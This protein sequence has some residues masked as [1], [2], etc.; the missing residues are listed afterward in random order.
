MRYLL[1]VLGL[2]VLC[3]ACSDI[4]S[5]PEPELPVE[6]FGFDEARYDETENSISLHIIG[7]FNT[8]IGLSATYNTQKR[9]EMSDYLAENRLI[10]Q[11]TTIGEFNREITIKLTDWA[12]IPEKLVFLTDEPC[13]FYES[14]SYE[15]HSYHN[16][17]VK[18][19]IKTREI[20]V[21]IP[22]PAP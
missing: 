17:T 14:G 13:Y 12:Q 10:V 18:A 3:A 20:A 4:N 6:Y 2:T 19:F 8:H 22:P 7:Y 21:T 11:Q 15:Y 1:F 16:V 5:L 9:F